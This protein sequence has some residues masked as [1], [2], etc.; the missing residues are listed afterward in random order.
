MVL[1]KELTKKLINICAQRKGRVVSASKLRLVTS[2]VLLAQVS[3]WNV[4]QSHYLIYLERVK[5][6]GKKKKKQTLTLPPFLHSS[7]WH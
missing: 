7:I 2:K 4:E 5:L 6:A 1:V 3:A